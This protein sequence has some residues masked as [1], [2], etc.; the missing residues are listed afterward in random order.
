MGLK[1][2]RDDSLDRKFEEFAMLP[3]Q[4]AD[5]NKEKEAALKRFLEPEPESKTEKTKKTD[6]S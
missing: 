2:Q 3:E 1:F 6:P 4:K 5:K